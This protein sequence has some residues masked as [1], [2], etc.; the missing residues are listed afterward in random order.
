[1]FEFSPSLIRLQRSLTGTFHCFTWTYVIFNNN[2]AFIWSCQPNSYCLIARKNKMLIFLKVKVD[3]ETVLTCTKDH[4]DIRYCIEQGKH[5]RVQPAEIY[6]NGNHPYNVLFK[7][8]K[9]RI[10]ITDHPHS[11]NELFRSIVSVLNSG[12]VRKQI[13]GGSTVPV[14]LG[15]GFLLVVLILIAVFT[16][17][18]FARSN[19]KNMKVLSE[20]LILSHLLCFKFFGKVCNKMNQTNPS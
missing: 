6:C 9:I 19:K 1:M 11:M 8:K 10:R 18:Y 5:S 20:Y 7:I 16:R 4:N 17:V 12:Y 3:L 15:V 14:I 2:S 13:T